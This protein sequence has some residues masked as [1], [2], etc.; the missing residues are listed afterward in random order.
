MHI[1]IPNELNVVGVND[2]SSIELNVFYYLYG[3][4]QLAKETTQ[5]SLKEI[6]EMCGYTETSKSRF[7]EHMVNIIKQ[8]VRLSMEVSIDKDIQFAPLFKF[9]KF[10]ED[11]GTVTV[12]PNEEANKIL[13]DICYTFLDVGEL[14]LLENKYAKL[15][16]SLLKQWRTTS[17]YKNG[18][19]PLRLEEVCDLFNLPKSYRGNTSALNNRVLYPAFNEMARIFKGFRVE[20]VKKGRV[21]TGYY[22]HFTPESKKIDFSKSEYRYEEET[23]TELP[24]D[25]EF[26]EELETTN[27]EETVKK[28]YPNYRKNRKI[29]KKETLPEWAKEGNQKTKDELLSE[30]D[31]KVFKER[32]KK[33]REF[34]KENKGQNKP[35]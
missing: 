9:A 22:I 7:S 14:I 10:N 18:K 11:L 32:L 4:S 33:I 30:E 15:M 24:L 5:I 3:V 26:E 8:V 19:T 35:T 23:I 25:I 29:V 1:R 16:Y 21:I 2:L 12:T 6:R 20:Q 13:K 28:V 31:Q 27:K 17:G 34:K